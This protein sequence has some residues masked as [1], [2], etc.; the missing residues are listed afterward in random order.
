MEKEAGEEGEN[1]EQIEGRVS[2]LEGFESFQCR[3]VMLQ[4]EQR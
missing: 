3:L 2:H 4:P 1:R